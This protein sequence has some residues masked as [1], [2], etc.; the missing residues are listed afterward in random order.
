MTAIRHESRDSVIDRSDEEG[1][2]DLARAR[3]N[4]RHENRP[5][6]STTITREDAI[7]SLGM[8]LQQGL[9]AGS[10]LN[11]DGPIDKHG[12]ANE[13]P[14]QAAKRRREERLRG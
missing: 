2:A 9:Q 5:K 4:Q 14:V 7:A 6:S 8:G 1:N 12:D 10:K 3:R 13:D 11:T